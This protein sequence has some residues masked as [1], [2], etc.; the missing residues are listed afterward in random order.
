VNYLIDTYRKN[1]QMQDVN[2][3]IEQKHREAKEAVKGLLEFLNAKYL[4]ELR[5][6]GDKK[7]EFIYSKFSYERNKIRD[8]PKYLRDIL[9]LVQTAIL[10]LYIEGER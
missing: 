2:F 7:A 10:K 6:D 3:N 4:S 1:L 8:E 9:K 5:K